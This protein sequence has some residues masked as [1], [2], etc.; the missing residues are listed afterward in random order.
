MCEK[1]EGSTRL[2]APGQVSLGEARKVNVCNVT[3]EKCELP[4]NLARARVQNTT[5]FS[6]NQLPPVLSA[7]VVYRSDTDTG[8]ATSR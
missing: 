2:P 4:I 8:R 7:R 6:G 5:D 3:R 1:G